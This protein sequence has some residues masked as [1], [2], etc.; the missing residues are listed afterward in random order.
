MCKAFE[1]VGLN[2]WNPDCMHEQCEMKATGVMPHRMSV[3]SQLSDSN[4]EA[5][6][7]GSHAKRVESFTAPNTALPK[8]EAS[9]SHQV[10]RGTSMVI[11]PPLSPLNQQ[12]SGQSASKQ[13]T[14]AAATTTWPHRKRARLDAVDHHGKESMAAQQSGSCAPRATS[15]FAQHKQQCT[16]TLH[17]ESLTTHA[18]CSRGRTPAMPKHTCHHVANSFVVLCVF[19]E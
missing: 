4:D 15:H 5:T 18:P 10:R 11:H 1:E 12:Q 2:P 14:V 9:V 6:R 7:F 13:S 16:P 3:A 19:T 8:Q 17:H